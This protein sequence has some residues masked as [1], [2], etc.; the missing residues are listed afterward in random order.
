MLVMN[1]H[2]TCD[3]AKQQLL[4]EK[5][6]TDDQYVV[7]ARVMFSCW[8]K[9]VLIEK[10]CHFLF[11]LADPRWHWFKTVTIARIELHYLEEEK[12]LSISL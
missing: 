4:S 6:G 12:T 5:Y 3:G 7:V 8:K 11:I 1:N 2:A 9:L 10:L